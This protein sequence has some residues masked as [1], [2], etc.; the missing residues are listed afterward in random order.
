[1][2]PAE[3][4]PDVPDPLGGAAF[5]LSEEFDVQSQVQPG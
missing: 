3:T 5:A 4:F 2:P 1:M